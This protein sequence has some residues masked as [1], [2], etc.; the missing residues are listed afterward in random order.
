MSAEVLQIIKRPLITE[1]GTALLESNVYSFEVATSATK[2]DIKRAIEKAFK[3]NV[4][5]VNTINSRG[6]ARRMGRYVSAVKHW[7]KALVRVKDGQK[8]K[9]FEGA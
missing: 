8:I 9:I 7:K 1:K 2:A 5:S 6:R 3:V 4:T